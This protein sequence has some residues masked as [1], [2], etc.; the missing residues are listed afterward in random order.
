MPT[1]SRSSLTRAADNKKW[2]GV[3][4]AKQQMKVVLVFF[5]I[6]FVLLLVLLIS[7]K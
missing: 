5:S 2:T 6:I 3:W 4:L 7:I 1:K